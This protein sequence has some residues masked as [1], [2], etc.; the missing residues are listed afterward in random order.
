MNRSEVQRDFLEY[1]QPLLSSEK[2]RAMDSI[3]HHTS[4]ITC[5]DH[6][7]YVAYISY[8]LA[9]KL[10][11][12]VASCTRSAL[13][14]DLYLCHWEEHDFG[15]YERLIIHPQMALHNARCFNLNEKE[16]RVIQ[17]HMWPINFSMIP[18]S[19][20][21]IIVNIA[22]KCCTIAEVT[23]LYWLFKC[24]TWLREK[25][26]NQLHYGKGICT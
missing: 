21:E 2:V 5:F 16:Q 19:K 9:K 15:V 3:I 20:E 24:R 7:I 4:H 11:G 22:D 23:G 1:I 10:R 12:D 17:N 13:L 25:K 14:H 6:S 8:L 26:E 18:T